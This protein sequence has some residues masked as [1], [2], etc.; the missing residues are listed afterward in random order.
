ML[1]FG[2]FGRGEVVGASLQFACAVAA[3]I[4]PPGGRNRP[5]AFLS[6][7]GPSGGVCRVARRCR[8]LVAWTWYRP[9]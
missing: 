2:V 6:L 3:A 8:H 1:P 5:G 7:A 4:L 9:P